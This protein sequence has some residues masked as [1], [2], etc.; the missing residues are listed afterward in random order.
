MKSIALSVAVLFAASVMSAQTPSPVAK[1][2][3][4]AVT[5]AKP[6]DPKAAP[7]KKDDKKKEVVY[8]IPGTTIP[9]ANGKFLGLQVLNT[10]YVLS[11]YDAKKKPMAPDVT[12]GL[13]RWPNTRGRG[14]Y[15]TT[16]N[17]NGKALVG[18]QPVTPPYNFNIF[19]TLLQ[20]EGDAAKAVENYTVQLH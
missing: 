14:D 19:I 11:F 20:G 1:P 2:A 12:R 16:L 4:P 17:S 5:P 13:A 3:D 10:V 18:A 7:A 8:T 6:G 9:R 15:R